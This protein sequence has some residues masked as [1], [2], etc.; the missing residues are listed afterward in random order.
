MFKKKAAVLLAIIIGVAMIFS[1]CSQ[2]EMFEDEQDEKANE[3]INAIE[4]SYVVEEVSEEYAG[5]TYFFPR[6]EGMTNKSKQADLNGH[7]KRAA[8][9]TTKDF[10]GER[11]V[12]AD[13]YEV[14]IMNDYLFSIRFVTTLDCDL[15]TRGVSLLVREHKFLFSIENLFG[16]AEDNAMFADMRAVLEENGAD[17]AMADDDFRKNLI[18]FEGEDMA[19]ITLHMTYYTDDLYDIAVPLADVMDY[20]LDEVYDMFEFAR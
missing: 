10:S 1:A 3:R 18:Y 5:V 16:R 7:M 13:S 20:M 8:L 19:D 9:K 2:T 17:S 12:V 6:I 11:G 15:S 4:T 14:L